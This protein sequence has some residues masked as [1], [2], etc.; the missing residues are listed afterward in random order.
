MQTDVVAQVRDRGGHLF[1]RD[2][3]Y[4]SHRRLHPHLERGDE[5]RSTLPAAAAEPASRDDKRSHIT[6]RW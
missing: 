2:K 1:V 5:Q 4:A 6:E 3:L